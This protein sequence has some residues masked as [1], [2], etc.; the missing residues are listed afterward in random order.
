MKG[1]KIYIS[2]HW[3]IL[4]KGLMTFCLLLSLLGKPIGE[5]IIQISG[6]EYELVDSYDEPN[7]EEIE[8]TSEDQDPQHNPLD[9][10]DPQL[11]HKNNSF[12]FDLLKIHVGSY[13]DN[14]FPP[15]DLL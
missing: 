11:A 7:S 4:F 2:F 9:R 8:E 15:P 10:S 14:P 13:P 5:L 12:N 3:T 6:I 1:K